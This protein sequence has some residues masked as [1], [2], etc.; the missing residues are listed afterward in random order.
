MMLSLI[1]RSSGSWGLILLPEST[2]NRGTVVPAGLWSDPYAIECRN[3]SRLANRASYSVDRL[4]EHFHAEYIHGRIF[5][6][7]HFPF[8]AHELALRY[9]AR[10]SRFGRRII[11]TE[12]FEIINE[13]KRTT[14]WASTIESLDVPGVRYVWLAYPEPPGET[15]LET[16]SRAVMNYLKDHIYVAR[17]LFPADVIIGI[18]FPNHTATPTSY[19]LAIFD[20][21]KWTEQAQ[22]GAEALRAE[23]GIFGNLEKLDR[24]H[25]P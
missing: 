16:V 18:A 3:R 14:F 23:R 15:D 7:T 17:A 9:M 19:F 12:L 2:G 13:A 24:R 8:E 25:V 5:Q 21:T 4:I 11:A 22:K 6:E 1:E 10:E 20:G